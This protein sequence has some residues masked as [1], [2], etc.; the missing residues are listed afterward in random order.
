LRD[1]FAARPK[2]EAAGEALAEP[3]VV[4]RVRVSAIWTQGNATLVLVNERIC[5]AGD[6]IGQVKI[7][8]A[9]QE[10]VWVSHWKGRDFLSLGVEFV[11]TTPASA[12][13]AAARIQSA[14]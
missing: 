1:P 7:E 13:H 10:G 14:L 2:R 5:E 11:L 9:S 12:T 8:S 3:D 4:D 6:E